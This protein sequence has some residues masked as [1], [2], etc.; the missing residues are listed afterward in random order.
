MPYTIRNLL[1]FSSCSNPEIVKHVAFE[2]LS[3][4]PLMKYLESLTLRVEQNLSDRLPDQFALLF[5]DLV[6]LTH[7]ISVL[8]SRSG[9]NK[10]GTELF[11]SDAHLSEMR[12]TNKQISTTQ[13]WLTS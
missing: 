8:E 1:S 2:E 13:Y 6:A 4:K 11:Y 5:M 12:R 10:M 3:V 7:Y 9:T